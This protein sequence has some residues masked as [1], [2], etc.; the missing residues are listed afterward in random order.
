MT[1]GFTE[2]AFEFFPRVNRTSGGP[3]RAEQSPGGQPVQGRQG[4]P[5]QVRRLRASVAQSGQRTG[6]FVCLD[7]NHD[8]Q[9][10][11]VPRW[12]CVA[13]TQTGSSRG[14]SLPRP[15]SLPPDGGIDSSPQPSPRSTRRGRDGRA[16]WWEWTCA[17]L[18]TVAGHALRRPKRGKDWALVTRDWEL[19]IWRSDECPVP[20]E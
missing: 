19:G 16:L 7:H 6:R 10:N 18:R 2:E 1:R 17:W 4:N 15:S 8:R 13:A 5:Q 14:C 12:D 20:S 3:G 9:G 11:E